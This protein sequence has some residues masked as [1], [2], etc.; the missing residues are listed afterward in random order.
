[1]AR[2]VLSNIDLNNVARIVNLP[3][4]VN[5]QEPATVA[6][7]NAAIE[8][9]SFKDDVVVDTTSNVNLAAPGATLNG[10]SMSASQRFLARGQ[11]T[12]SENGIY[13]WNG[14]ASPATRAPD[15]SVSAEFNQAVTLVQQGPN[16]GTSWRQ[17]AVNPTVGTTAIAFV[18]AFGTS[19][20]AAETTSGI[21]EL[22]TQAETDAGTDDARMVTPLKLANYAGRVRKFSQDIGDGSATQYTVTHNLGTKDLHVAVFRNSGAFDEVGCDIEHTSTTTITVRFASAPAS[23]AFRVVVV[24]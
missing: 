15:M 3:D 17:T 1:M 16:A 22:A 5:P 4:G 21:A 18:S 8:G 11:S 12:G 9:L 20:P 10:V 23:N 7:L 24:G 14:A 13:F 2:Q 19:P 6:Q